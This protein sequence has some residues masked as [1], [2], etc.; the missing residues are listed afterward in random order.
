M[1]QKCTNSKLH[2]LPFVVF[3]FGQ[4]KYISVFIY[5]NYVVFLTKILKTLT[6]A[7]LCYKL[8]GKKIESSLLQLM[9]NKQYLKVRCFI[10]SPIFLTFILHYRYLYFFGIFMLMHF[11][12]V[13]MFSF[14]KYQHNMDGFPINCIFLYLFS[15]IYSFN[16]VMKSY[17]DRKSKQK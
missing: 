1:C 13:K 7:C 11:Q 12:F 6:T 10:D 2:L 9:L 14:N 4:H 8:F 5:T 17:F 16:S 3:T 15:V